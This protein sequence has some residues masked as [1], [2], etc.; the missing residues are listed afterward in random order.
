MSQTTAASYGNI[1]PAVAG[2][3]YDIRPD[4]VVT[5]A[6]EAALPFGVGVTY[7]TDSDKQCKIVSSAG[8]TFYGVSL[9]QQTILPSGGANQY[10]AKDAVS[11]LTSGAVYVEVTSDVAAGAAAYVDI[12]NGKFTDVSTDNLAVPNGKFEKAATSGNLA[13]LVIK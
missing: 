1:A 4:T 8:N 12:A 11:I 3:K 2:G 6:A 9:F 5:R 13:V 7:G 10:A